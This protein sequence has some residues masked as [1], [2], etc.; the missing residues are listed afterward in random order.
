MYQKI[1]VPVDRSDT[2]ERA[3]REAILLARSLR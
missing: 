3:L 2:A 1:I